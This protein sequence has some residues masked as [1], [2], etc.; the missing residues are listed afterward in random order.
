MNNKKYTRGLSTS[1]II[2]TI[3]VIIVIAGGWYYLSTAQSTKS[4]KTNPISQQPVAVKS[5]DQ[6]TPNCT[7]LITMSDLKNIYND[8]SSGSIRQYPGYSSRI[9]NISF[10]LSTG[11]SGTI[12]LDSGTGSI[13]ANR[14]TAAFCGSSLGV[15]TPFPIVAGYSNLGI[16]D[17]SSCIANMGK[18]IALDFSK[19]GIQVNIQVGSLTSL[20][21]PT[22]NLAKLIAGKL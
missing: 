22:I 13:P 8:S 14:E 16:G 21:D 5:S 15:P 1:A 20:Y 10:P 17:S 6:S 3:A 4:A 7:G 2:L 19:N 12:T 18:N 11:T 9:C